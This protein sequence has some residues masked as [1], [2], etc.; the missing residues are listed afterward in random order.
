M[1]NTVLILLTMTVMASLLHAQE[2]A[3]AAQE[4]PPVA[5]VSGGDE[6]VKEKG[7]FRE[8]WVHPDADLTR[9]SKLYL[10]NAAF[11]FRDVGKTRSAGTTSSILRGTV[12]EYP[13]ARE[14]RQRFVQVVVNAFVK[15]LNRS[16]TFQV[17]EEVGPDTLILRGAVLDIVSNVPPRTRR[18]DVYLSAVGEGTIVVELIDAETG[19][20]QARVGE[21]RRIQPPGAR[22]PADLFARPANSAAVWTDVE[23][24]ARAVASDLRRGL[25]KA[26]KSK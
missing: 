20:I 6:L 12:G 19:V 21:R 2:P 3:P 11:R 18:V 14:S 17:V 7:R 9:Y 8:T 5:E 25:E 13:V 10:W 22:R 26:Q 16:K 4:D 24:W 1:K 23:R 15:E